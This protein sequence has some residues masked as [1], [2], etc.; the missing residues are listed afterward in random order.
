MSASLD[1]V[2]QACERAN[3]Q[4]PGIYRTVE[5]HL[6]LAFV[7]P[8]S[9]RMDYRWRGTVEAITPTRF[10]ERRS[11][12]SGKG[13]E[14][15]PRVSAQVDGRQLEARRHGT[16]YRSG[17]YE[18]YLIDLGDEI[19]AGTR[20]NIQTESRYVDEA[21]T[22]KPFLSTS[23]KPS[24]EAL[25]LTVESVTELKTCE[26]VQLDNDG[27]QVSV[28]DVSPA[29]QNGLYIYFRE[30]SSSILGRHRLIW[31]WE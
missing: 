11:G 24:L 14:G 27:Q 7:E 9:F 10:F 5:T 30:I 15:P 19:A 21:A 29:R 22:F 25:S 6:T 13:I 20:V 17:D 3:V 12:W 23:T 28:E 4:S 26:Y 1:D 16:V 31:K 18:K 2:R 8:N